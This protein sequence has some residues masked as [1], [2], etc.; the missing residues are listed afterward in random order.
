MSLNYLTP[1]LLKEAE[2][3]SQALQ[4]DIIKLCKK[5]GSF[6]SAPVP[7]KDIDRM[8]PFAAKEELVKFIAAELRK[9]FDDSP[10]LRSSEEGYYDVIS[11]WYCVA[12]LILAGDDQFM[13]YFTRSFIDSKHKDIYLLRRLLNNA[14]TG[15]VYRDQVEAYFDEVNSKSDIYIWAKGI[16]LELPGTHDWDFYVCLQASNEHMFITVYL[17][18]KAPDGKG[19]SYE[20]R[21]TERG[22]RID[23][24]TEKTVYN[25]R[26]IIAELERTYDFKFELTSSTFRGK[27][28]NKTAV[29]KWLGL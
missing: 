20:V 29:K 12:L 21:I 26:E 2:T 24:A 1:I 14:G 11:F 13:P 3:K 8:E 7:K 23:V 17:I 28:K 5:L 25:L 16:G 15:S 9:Y 19:N 6:I 18:G 22:S 4:A 27:I 10:K